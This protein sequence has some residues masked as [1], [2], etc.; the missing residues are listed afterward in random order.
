MSTILL[1]LLAFQIKHYI[2]DFVLQTPYQFTNKGSYGHPG[3]IVHAGLHALGSIPALL[4]LAAPLGLLSAIILGE[5]VVHYHVDWS[6]EQLVRHFHLAEPQPTFWYVFGADQLA[7]QLTYIA[8][9]AI[10]A[11]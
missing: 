5:F 3:G 10:V 2:F 1:A 6:K 8:M 9:V 7:H 4:I 11:G